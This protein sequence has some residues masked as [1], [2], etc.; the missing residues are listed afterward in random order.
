MKKL[1]IIFSLI[2]VGCAT[3]AVNPKLAKITPENRIFLSETYN[4][5]AGKVTVIRDSGVTNGKMLITMYID[6]KRAAEMDTSEKVTFNVNSG[7]HIIGVTF[8]GMF[9]SSPD[10]IMQERE[11]TISEGDHKYYRIFTDQFVNLDIKPTMLR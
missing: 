5:N 1:L 4:E 11:F 3:S 10:E 9:F 2:M 6:G 7:E 8:E